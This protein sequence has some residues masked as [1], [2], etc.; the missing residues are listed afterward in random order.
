MNEICTLITERLNELKDDKYRDFH[1]RLIPTISYDTILGVR[2]PALRKL[3]KELAKR[4][5]VDGFL[6]ALPHTYYDENTLHAVLLCGVKDFDCA[7]KLVETFLPYVDNWA[8]CDTLAPKVFAKN[9]DRLMTHVDGWLKSGHTYTVR[10]GVKS[11]M[12]YYL[13]EHFAIEQAENV[14]AIRSE[15]YYVNM[16]KAW[17]FATALAK[18]YDS[19]LP[20]IIEQRLDKWSHNKAIQ[21]AIESYRITPEQKTYLRSLKI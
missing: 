8:T 16:M 18:Q 12:T 7:V 4:P 2:L 17:Y 14:A 19:V 9:T 3:A 21:K 1:S 11:L 20:I 10:F 5:D 6:S 13:D 15:E